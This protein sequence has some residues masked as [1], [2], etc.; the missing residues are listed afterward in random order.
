[1]ARKNFKAIQGITVDSYLIPYQT[2]Q[3]VVIT[4]SSTIIDTTP[5][6]SFNSIKYILTIKQGS[7]IRTSNFIVQTDGTSVDTTEY[8]ITETGGAISGVVV[9]ASTSGTDVVLQATITD[10]AST[11]AKIIGIKKINL[12]F[13]G[14]TPDAPTDVSASIDSDT[15]AS[16][17][18]TAP[19]DDGG[20]ATSYLVTE[21]ISNTTVTGSSSPIIFSNLNTGSY[22]F[23]VKTK[24]ENAISE[25]SSSSNSISIV[26]YPSLS[27]GTLASDS[28]YYYR[29][30]TSS[31]NLVLSNANLACDYLVVAGGGAGGSTYWG[32]GGGGGGYLTS[33]GL[34]GGGSAAGSQLTLTPSTYAITIGA[35]GTKANYV[36]NNGSNSSISTLVVA[37][38]GGGGVHASNTGSNGGSGGG[39][40]VGGTA[41][42]SGQGYNGGGYSGSDGNAGGGG[43]GGAGAVGGTCFSGSPAPAG[44]IG[45]ASASSFGAATST[46]HNVSGTRYYAGGGGGCS[47][48]AGGGAGG[49]GGGGAGSS[50]TATNGT[51]NTGGGGGGNERG[52][53]AP[54]TNQGSG[55]SG[56]VIVR[57]LKTAVGG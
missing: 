10:A 26:G 4:N 21:S 9:A 29:T 45:S 33:V 47:F 41:S 36:G 12:A 28:T 11:I 5:I 25:A 51:A 6:A 44:G 22:T 13:V 53:G 7:K 56:I 3:S 54:N 34:S 40:R 14:M 23:T 19:Y 39:G 1:V 16:I 24:N 20:G 8:A 35:G 46:G 2:F 48:Q 15:S 49:S 30:F 27:G 31:D 37:T 18:F 42:P 32:G 43:G 52:T 50:T 55:G 17:S 38:G 57:Y